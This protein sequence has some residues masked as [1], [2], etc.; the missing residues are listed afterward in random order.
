VSAARGLKDGIMEKAQRG[1]PLPKSSRTRNRIIGKLRY[2][3]EQGFG[4]L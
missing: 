4:T 3:V 1:H 2:V